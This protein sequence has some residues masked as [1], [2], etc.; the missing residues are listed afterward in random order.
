[1]SADTPIAVLGAGSWGTALAI[2]FA[3]GGGPVRL[4]G[5]DGVQ[6]ARLAGAR[7]NERYLPGAQFPSSLA[8][9]PDLDAALSDARDVLVVVP[10]QALRSILRE[11]APRLAPQM[12]VA[13]ATKGFEQGSG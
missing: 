8:V 7:C 3:R 10:S 1:M 4:W 13:W 11:L 9:E 5:R 6:L 2:Q 12:H